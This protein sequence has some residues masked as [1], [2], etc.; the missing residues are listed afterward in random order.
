MGILYIKKPSKNS[1]LGLWHITESVETLLKALDLSPAD[2][3]IYQTKKNDKRKK[4]WLACR[5]LL[6]GMFPEKV[7]VYYDQEG[8]PYLDENKFQISMSHSGE[9]AC[10]YAHEI[11]PVGVDVQKLKPGIQK[12]LDF[13]INETERGWIDAEDNLMLHIIWSVKESVFKYYGLNELDMK[14]DV[15]V[16]SFKSNQN[17]MIEVSILN[18]DL[19]NKL[20]ITFEIFGDYVLTYTT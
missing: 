17:A 11:K 10:V 6:N 2:R 3:E 19:K 16:S 8:K 18:H 5:N 12:G 1:L 7:K 20:F 9:Y 15:T 14:K 13:F 4:E